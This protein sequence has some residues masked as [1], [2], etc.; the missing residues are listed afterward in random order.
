MASASGS[1]P[2]SVRLGRATVPVGTHRKMGC[3]PLLWSCTAVDW[4]ALAVKKLRHGPA[5]T[6]QPHE[7]SALRPYS[8]HKGAARLSPRAGAALSCAGRSRQAFSFMRN[9][10]N[11]RL[12]SAQRNDLHRTVL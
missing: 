1:S 2:A 4:S 8:L 10:F 6:L 11:S 9:T 3:G 7:H 5:Q 12:G